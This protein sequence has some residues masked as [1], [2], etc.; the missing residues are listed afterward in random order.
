MRAREGAPSS[1]RLRVDAV[2]AVSQAQR[3][4]CAREVE[5]WVRINDP[6]LFQDIA[7]KCYDYVRI[8]LSLAP[9]DML[10][11]YQTRAPIPRVD[12]RSAFY[13]LPAAHYNP[14]QWIAASTKPYRKVG[15][16]AKK[17]E[18]LTEPPETPILLT[19][20]PS[21][22]F[23]PTSV[24]LPYVANVDQSTYSTSWF[25]ITCLITPDDAIW[26]DL[27]DAIRFMK[28]EVA[29]GRPPPETLEQILIDRP[30][31]THPV[32][33]IDVVNILSK[34]A[35]QVQE[36]SLVADFEFPFELEAAT[37]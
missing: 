1:V 35:A 2:Q 22:I 37:V 26:A 25:A 12:Q 28:A 15:S 23:F 16:C 10:I 33:A 21:S 24:I 3:P 6:E 27:T 4:L 19:K 30:A 8:I 36:D 34:E 7:A 20:P 14:N 31:L 13:G 9:S 29:R 5:Q 11:K 32:V 18:R 17:I